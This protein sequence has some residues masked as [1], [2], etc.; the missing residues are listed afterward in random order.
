TPTLW[1]AIS[2]NVLS[3]GGT[4]LFLN[5]QGGY[6]SESGWS[7]SGGGQSVLESR[8]GAESSYF[9]SG[10]L[11]NITTAQKNSTKNLGPDVSY[12]ANP[13]T[14]FAVYDSLPYQGYSG[15]Q[16]YGGTSAGAP[17][18]A[19]LIAIADQLRVQ[20]GQG[21]LST[22]G[23]LNGLFSKS[24]YSSNFHDVTSGA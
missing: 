22:S 23:V 9:S 13:S 1:P 19:A 8:P 17:Q 10:G 5:A 2:S 11:T 3:V 4:S 16:Q 6:S 20:N 12:D 14:G 7:G 15:W 18:W 24:T 21:E